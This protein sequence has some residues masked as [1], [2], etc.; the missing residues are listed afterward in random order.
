MMS[1]ATT[2][3]PMA[4]PALA[5]VERP[6]DLCS[7]TAPVGKAVL[8]LEVVEPVVVVAALLTPMQMP[9]PAVL[10]AQFCPYPQQ[11]PPSDD[12]QP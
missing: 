9:A 2:M 6:D 5:P 7:I 1:A 11:P 3:T 4:M 12:G 8:L 10:V